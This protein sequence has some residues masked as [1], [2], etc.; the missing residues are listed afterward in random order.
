M[1]EQKKKK[2]PVEPEPRNLVA[3]WSAI[4]AEM[5]AV[6]KAGRNEF[7]KYSYIK[8]SDIMIA[9]KPLLKKHGV[10]IFPSIESCKKDGNITEVWATFIIANTDNPDETIKLQFPGYGMDSGDKGAYKAITGATKYF[11]MKSFLVAS[12]DDPENEKRNGNHAPQNERQQAQRAISALNTADEVA[13]QQTPATGEYLYKPK[14]DS[15]EEFMQAKD[16]VKAGGARWD[17]DRK[18]WVAQKEIPGAERWLVN[19]GQREDV[20]YDVPQND[21]VPEFL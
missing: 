15:K 16:F 6:E 5:P 19:G 1:T 18:I 14:G 13:T 17:K 3:R 10:A 11:C 8:E 9:L 21:G 20:V 12:D 4:Q 7:H 2:E